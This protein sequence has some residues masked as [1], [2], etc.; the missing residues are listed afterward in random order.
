MSNI[1]GV[2]AEIDTEWWTIRRL[3]EG[4]LEPTIGAAL[5]ER[6]A[7]TLFENLVR[8]QNFLESKEMQGKSFSGV[9][10]QQGG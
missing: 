4:C 6:E 9:A 7:V 10:Y 3:I 1:E 8:F 5:S 2:I